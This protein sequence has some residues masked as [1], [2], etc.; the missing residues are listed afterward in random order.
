MIVDLALHGCRAVIIGA[1][2]EAYRRT[3]ALLGEGCTVLVIGEPA[4]ARFDA[5]AGDS[6]ELRRERVHDASAI[7]GCGAR[8]VVAAT[9]DTAL[10]ST[11]VEAARCE[12]NC[13]AYSSD[14]AANSDYAHLAATR[15]SDSVSFAVSTGGKSPVMARILRERAAGALD[16]LVGEGDEA[17][18]A[19]QAEMRAAARGRIATPRGRRRFLRALAE[20]DGVKQLIKDGRA[21]AARDRAMSILETWDGA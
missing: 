1:G 8:I 6:F 13:L 16:G 17:H 20:D 9:D 4:D 11:I 18:I 14:D 10:N 7:R 3:R 15:L 2:S 21:R 5:L 12:P 19:L